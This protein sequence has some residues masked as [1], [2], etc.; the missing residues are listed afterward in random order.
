MWLFSGVVGREKTIGWYGMNLFISSPTIV[1]TKD[2]ND[3]KGASLMNNKVQ[4]KH[5]IEH[6]SVEPHSSLLA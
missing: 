4:R 1:W 6:T 5:I 3:I 2:V